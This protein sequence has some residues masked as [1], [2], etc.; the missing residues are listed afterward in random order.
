MDHLNG[1]VYYG[2]FGKVT[3]KEVY[4]YTGESKDDDPSRKSYWYKGP[5]VINDFTQGKTYNFILQTQPFLS[6]LGLSGYFR[7]NVGLDEL[8]VPVKYNVLEDVIL[9]LN[10]GRISA[11]QRGY[12]KIADVALGDMVRRV[13]TLSSEIPVVSPPNPSDFRMQLQDAYLFVQNRKETLQQLSSGKH[14]ISRLRMV[15]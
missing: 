3:C 4:F 14:R 9:S 10:S 2:Y 7:R 13:N 12:A 8:I 1:L 15:S 5:A 11:D 6:F